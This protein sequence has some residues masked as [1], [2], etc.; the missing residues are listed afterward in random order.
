MTNAHIHLT[1]HIVYHSPYNSNIQ[2]IMK[3]YIAFIAIAL[4]TTSCLKEYP[5]GQLTE[6]E[7]YQSAA[8]IERNCVG[9][10]YNYIGSGNVSEGLMGTERGVYDF[11]SLT[12]DEQMIP[13]RGGDW[14]DGGFWNR[15][16]NHTWKPTET[17]LNDTWNYLYKVI[18]LANRSLNIIEKHRS[19]L[20]DAQYQAYTAE[21]KSI[22]AMFYFYTMD[23]FG[24]ITMD[25]DLILLDRS[26]AYQRI[27]ADLQGSLPYLSA[28]ASN[29]EG[30]MYGRVTKGVVYFLLAKLALNAEIYMDDNW[31]D[32]NHLD[33]K[34]IT[35]QVGEKKL[36]AWEATIAYCD[37]LETR[38]PYY[39]LE[40]DYQ[41]NFSVYNENSKENIF[42][43]PM[44]NYQNT[45]RFKYIF[46]SIHYAHASAIGMDAENGTCATISTMKAYGITEDDPNRRTTTPD[47]RL[48][49][50]FFIDTVYDRGNLVNDGYGHALVYHPMEVTE[51]LTGSVYEKIAGARM[52]KYEID[53]TALDDHK[54]QNNDIVLYRLAD[55]I[56]MKAEALVRNGQNGDNE[57]NRIRDRV[58]MPHIAA[59]L[60]N[61]L[62]ERLLELMWEGWRRNDLIRFG[63]YTS[64]YNDRI[65]A[66]D[67][68]T[69]FTTVFPI[70][71]DV[72]QLHKGWTQNYGYK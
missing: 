28:E 54:V 1:A 24:R 55:A 60:D 11:N 29:H 13:V 34:E 7:A 14:E 6:D 53:Y 57:L 25:D 18:G 41:T 58:G 33:G 63:K 52:R 47:N 8:D 36:N 17:E 56:L 69:G 71:Y 20:T 23:L 59:T 5:K 72:L 31:T 10:L 39:Q 45:N 62:N 35:I 22:R 27:I 21:V 2:M 16:Y 67:D 65:N 46:R 43:I 38:Q 19:T 48:A 49:I 42:T 32:G 70:P 64:H 61:I 3:K 37:S 68:T 66:I 4:L 15:L 44:N 51:D 30:E 26:K 9:D 40:S 12:T 50:N